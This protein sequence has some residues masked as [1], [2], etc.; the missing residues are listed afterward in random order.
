MVLVLQLEKR[1]YI[2]RKEEFNIAI[3]S[4][5]QLN[6][7]SKSSSYLL[8]IIQ[9]KKLYDLFVKPKKNTSHKNI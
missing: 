9:T 8:V 5:S 7:V 1:I 3:Y 6:L 4:N 2:I